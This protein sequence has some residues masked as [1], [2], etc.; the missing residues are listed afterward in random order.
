MEQFQGCGIAIVDI[1][2]KRIRS[3]QGFNTSDIIV[4]VS[5]GW[6]SHKQPHEWTAQACVQP[7]ESLHRHT[8]QSRVASVGGLLST[9][10]TKIYYERVYHGPFL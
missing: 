1:K 3:V 8:E 2:T 10:Y 4:Y 5:S 6:E 7:H 9:K